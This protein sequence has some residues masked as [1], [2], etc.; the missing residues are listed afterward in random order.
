MSP[1]SKAFFMSSCGNLP[2][3]SR[4]P[5]TGA[6][7]LREKSRAVW[8]RAFCASVRLR[9]NMDAIRAIAAARCQPKS[10]LR[11]YH[12]AMSRSL[13]AR[14]HRKFGTRHSGADRA[15]KVR[16]RV[17]AFRRHFGLTGLGFTP[18]GPPG[19]PRVAV[20]GGGFAGLA[21]GWMLCQRDATVTVYE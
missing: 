19:S 12:G 6:T 15:R 13:Y 8:I 21:A 11:C 16:Q 1:V 3:S 7:S 20:I 9:L 18:K 2:S 10:R 17:D 4:W 5:A 14:L